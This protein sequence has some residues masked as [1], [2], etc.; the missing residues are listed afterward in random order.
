MDSAQ[1]L[2]NCYWRL[3]N[4]MQ[5]G[6]EVSGKE[7]GCQNLSHKWVNRNTQPEGYIINIERMT[8]KLNSVPEF[9]NGELVILNMLDVWLEFWKACT[10]PNKLLG[11]A[12]ALRNKEPARML[13][14]PRSRNMKGYIQI[15]TEDIASFIPSTK[16]CAQLT[17]TWEWRWITALSG[18]WGT[19][20]ACGKRTLKTN[21]RIWWAFVRIA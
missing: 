11:E 12:A 21:G 14:K 5:K 6:F 4:W 9:W 15:R 16:W 20:Y 18:N 10:W 13:T 1:H 2:R 7:V 19:L 17:E 8:L 3:Q